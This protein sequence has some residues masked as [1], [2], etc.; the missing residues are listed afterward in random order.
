ML[1]VKTWIRDLDRVS[2]SSVGLDVFAK[3][4]TKFRES[5]KNILRFLYQLLIVDLSVKHEHRH[6]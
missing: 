2:D 6:G 3:F 1:H 5:H 4:L